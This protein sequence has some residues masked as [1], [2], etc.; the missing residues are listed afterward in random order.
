MVIELETVP[1]VL[2]RGVVV[3]VYKGGGKDPMRRDSITLTSMVSKV[4]EFLMLERLE[5]VF[6]A[7]GLPSTNRPTEGLCPVQKPSLRHKK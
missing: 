7:A 1:E 3:P 4:L 2:K 5:S 6:V